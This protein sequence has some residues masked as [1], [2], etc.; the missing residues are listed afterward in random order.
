MCE[1]F[2]FWKLNKDVHKMKNKIKIYLHT[3]QYIVVPRRRYFDVYIVQT[4]IQIFAVFLQNINIK[5]RD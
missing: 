5:T 4:L 1:N 2:L 3:I